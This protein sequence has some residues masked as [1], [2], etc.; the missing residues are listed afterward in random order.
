MPHYLTRVKLNR[1]KGKTRKNRTARKNMGQ[2]VVQRGDMQ[3]TFDSPEDFEKAMGMTLAE[4]SMPPMP[5]RKRQGSANRTRG[6]KKTTRRKAPTKNPLGPVSYIQGK[7][8]GLSVGRMKAYCPA[9]E[10]LES[11]G[12]T[13]TAMG[14]RYGTA[15]DVLTALEAGGVLREHRG[16]PFSK[17]HAEKAVAILQRVGGISCKV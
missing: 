4:F 14:L 11:H 16:V 6:R 3:V 10:Q 2:V 9:A 17:A 1:T 8:I 13:L 5:A 12:A 15:S 7:M